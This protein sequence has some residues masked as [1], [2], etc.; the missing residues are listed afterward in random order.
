[1]NEIYT[2]SFSGKGYRLG[3]SPDKS[4]GTAQS[5]TAISSTPFT[6]KGYKLGSA[7]ATIAAKPPPTLLT[8]FTEQKKIAAGL[9]GGHP[10]WCTSDKPKSSESS[11]SQKRPAS[12]VIVI[13]DEEAP[14]PQNAST[15]SWICP[16]CTCENPPLIL[17]CMVCFSV[18]PPQAIASQPLEKL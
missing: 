16:A 13:S 2:S 17:Q 9:P 15:S 18:C 3:A 7:P 8:Y 4:F 6:G 14:L 12:E 5:G 10:A 11:N 1:M